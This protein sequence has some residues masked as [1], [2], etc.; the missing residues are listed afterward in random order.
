MDADRLSGR[1]G[2]IAT[3]DESSIARVDMDVKWM[4]G[5]GN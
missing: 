3:G 4:K 5:M 1:T 2:G